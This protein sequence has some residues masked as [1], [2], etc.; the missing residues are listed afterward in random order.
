MTA[1]HDTD[2]L[3]KSGDRVLGVLEPTRFYSDELDVVVERF[4]PTIDFES[5]RCQHIP[6]Y[7]QPA[8]RPITKMISRI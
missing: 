6:P 7:I 8:N 5:F 1:V 3:L 4:R 2:L